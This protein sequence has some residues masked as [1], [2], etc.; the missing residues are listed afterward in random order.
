MFSLL[1][2]SLLVLLVSSW[3]A[4]EQS[5]F[6][7]EM[8]VLEKGEYPRWDTWTSSYRSDRLMSFRPIRMVSDWD[9]GEVYNEPR[10]LV[11]SGCSETGSLDLCNSANIP[12]VP[13]PGLWVIQSLLCSVGLE[14]SFRRVK[15]TL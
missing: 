13:H 15:K 2:P 8:F 10:S 14:L 1:S 3:V 5:A 12:S 4:F 7:G 6:R 9:W 11:T